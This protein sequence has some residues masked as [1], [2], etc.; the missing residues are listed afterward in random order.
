V[1]LDGQVFKDA[2]TFH[3]VAHT[4]VYQVLRRYAG[5]VL[6]VEVDLTLDEFAVFQLQQPGNGLK[7]GGLASA[8]AAQQSHHLTHRHGQGQA[9]Q[10]LHDLVV[11]HLDIGDLQHRQA[12]RVLYGRVQP[13]H[14]PSPE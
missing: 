1:L 5:D 3:D 9:A 6:P 12:G 14:P 8:I 7:R 11:D 13:G 2:P 10:Y 4:A